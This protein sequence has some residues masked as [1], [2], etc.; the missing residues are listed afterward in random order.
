MEKNSKFC[1]KCK[2]K[3]SFKN[4]CKDKNRSDGLSLRCRDCAKSYYKKNRGDILVEK[5]EYYNK[6]S[7]NI[8][9]K[10]KIYYIKNKNSIQEYR[11]SHWSTSRNSQLIYH[12]GIT[13]KD[14][15]NMLE[16][17]DYKCKICKKEQ[18]TLKKPLVVD[19]NHTTGKIRGLLCDN[20]NVGLG[21]FNDSVSLCKECVK[22]LEEND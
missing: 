5:E 7:K 20:C 9:R 17:Q 11:Q 21:R 4:F 3:L 12:Y 15:E 14:Y 1:Y 19:H 22:Y 16:K 6:N 13:L 2:R 8:L 18:E 10:K